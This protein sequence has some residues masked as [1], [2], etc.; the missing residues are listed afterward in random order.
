[1]AKVT[2]ESLVEN[3]SRLEGYLSG[4]ATLNEEYQLEAYKMLLAFM[5]GAVRAEEMLEEK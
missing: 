5:V 2:K 3:I 1:M 4:G